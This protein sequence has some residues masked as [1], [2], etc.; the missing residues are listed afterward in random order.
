M[1]IDELERVSL[2]CTVST[3]HRQ[4]VTQADW[5]ETIHWYANRSSTTVVVVPAGLSAACNNSVWPQPGAVA[6]TATMGAPAQGVASVPTPATTAGA[7]L[8]GPSGA[9]TLWPL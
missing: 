6:A 8:Q 4:I 3:D 5:Y 7:R 2:A 9:A 1:G